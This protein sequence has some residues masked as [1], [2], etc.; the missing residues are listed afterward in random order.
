MHLT[1][2]LFFC[3]TDSK[4]LFFISSSVFPH[5]LY[6]CFSKTACKDKGRGCGHRLKS[7]EN[8]KQNG[9]NN[10]SAYGDD[11]DFFGS[12]VVFFIYERQT[13]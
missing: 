3:C 1:F 9:V 12:A 5:V 8:P 4:R 10:I 13:E 11:L 6:L 2:L 7:R